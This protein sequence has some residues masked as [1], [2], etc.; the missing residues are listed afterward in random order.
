MRE[1]DWWIHCEVFGWYPATELEY[2]HRKGFLHNDHDFMCRED[3]P[4]YSSSA[5]AM[6]VLKKCSEKLGMFEYIS[7]NCAEGEFAI[8]MAHAGWDWINAPTMELAIC[9]FAKKLFS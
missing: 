6:E 5:A 8:R 7:I 2:P 9:Q 3:V 1:L 4:E